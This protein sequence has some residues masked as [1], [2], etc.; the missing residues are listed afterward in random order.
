MM[1]ERVKKLAEEA[2]QLTRAERAELLD[3]LNALVQEDNDG[4]LYAEGEGG[5]DAM[6]AES[7]GYLFAKS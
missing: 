1:T 4:P 7:L 5:W 3:A 6:G 2:R